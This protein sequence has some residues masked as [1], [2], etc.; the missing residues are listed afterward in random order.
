[1]T[2]VFLN[3]GPSLSSS[4][5][6]C[7]SYPNLLHVLPI[8]SAGFVDVGAE[9]ML[10]IILASRLCARLQLPEPCEQLSLPLMKRPL[11]RNVSWED[12]YDA[13]YRLDGSPIFGTGDKG[14]ERQVVPQ[15]LFMDQLLVAMQMADDGS[16]FTWH[17]IGDFMD[18][19]WSIRNLTSSLVSYQ[20]KCFRGDVQKIDAPD[21][22]GGPISVE[23]AS[24]ISSLIQAIKRAYSLSEYYTLHLR[25]GDAVEVCD[26][27]V[28]ASNH[29]LALQSQ[30][31]R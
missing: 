23:F 25:R 12:Y 14:V 10:L 20:K 6:P 22:R 1:M 5:E 7:S 30:P 31:Q 19:G 29:P 15:G 24:P 26:P 16:P 18:P 4:C 21:F 3:D 17:M 28:R 8:R 11:A 13:T 9:L 27:S 2:S